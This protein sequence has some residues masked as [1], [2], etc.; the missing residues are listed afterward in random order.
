MTY[1][2]KI[3]GDN[4]IELT[5]RTKSRGPRGVGFGG[6]NDGFSGGTGGSG[7]GTDGYGD[8]FGGVSGKSAKFVIKRVVTK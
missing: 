5:F 6:F 4:E 2:G 1:I 3:I 7:G 8:G